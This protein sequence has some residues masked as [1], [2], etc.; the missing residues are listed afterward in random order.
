MLGTMV[1]VIPALTLT[2]VL[3]TPRTVA[4]LM[5]LVPTLQAVTRALVMLGTM[6]TVIHAWAGPARANMDSSEL[7]QHALPTISAARVTVHIT[8]WLVPGATMS[9]SVKMMITVV[10]QTLLVTTT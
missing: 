1:M 9:T 10:M 4:T 7:R 2:S 8:N 6:A 3:P 5:P